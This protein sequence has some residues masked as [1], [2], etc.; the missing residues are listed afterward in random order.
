MSFFSPGRLYVQNLK[1]ISSFE[2]ILPYAEF[3]RTEA[4]VNSN[5]PVDLDRI[6]S[7]FDIPNPNLLH[8]PNNRVCS[9]IRNWELLLLIPLTRKSARNSRRPMN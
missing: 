8:Y 1:G 3:L 7:H 9:W 5:L 4:G 2:D 6:F